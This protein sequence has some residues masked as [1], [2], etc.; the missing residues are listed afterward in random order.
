[1]S[2]ES[3][4]NPILWE[5]SPTLQST[6]EITRFMRWLDGR[7][8]SFSRYGDLWQWSV[9]DV[10]RFWAAVYEYFLQIKPQTVLPERI[11]PG[12]QWFGDSQVNFAE[13]VF[14]RARR[15]GVLIT[16]ENES[17]ETRGLTYQQLQSQVKGLAFTFREWGI[18]PGDRIAAYLPNIPETVVAFLAAASIGAIWS[19]ASPDF[20]P[21]SVLDRFR[22]IDPTVLL[23]VDGYRYNGRDFDR[24][25]VVHRLVEGLPSLRHVVT[26]PYLFPNADWT[27]GHAHAV[28]W[29]DVVQDRSSLRFEPVSFNHPLWVLYSSG[30]TGLPK[31]IVHGHG[32]ML[33]T[34]LVNTVLHLNLSQSDQFFWF[35]TTGWMM[36]NVVISGLLA[37]SGIVLYDG[38]PTHPSP[39]HLW[40]LAERVGVTVF[41]ASAAYLHG[42]MKAGVSPGRSH[43]LS[44]LKTLATTGSPL[45]PE[46]YDWVYEM[47]KP[48]I[49]L[50]PA[51]GGTDICSPFVGGCPLLPVRRGEM[52]CRILGA[53]VEAF[54]E[55]GQALI[56]AVGELVVT[57]PMPAMPLFLW[58]DDSQYTRYKQ[59][60]FEKFP[61]VWTHGDWIR[62]TPEGG[63]VI[64]G[65]SD[66][67]LNRYGVRM[68]TSE[69][70][71]A[72]ARVPEVDDALVV[73]YSP[74]PGQSFMPLFV[75]LM[76]GEHWS[77]SVSEHIR[78]A[79]TTA[80]SPRHLPDA[81]IPVEDIPRTLS[82]KKLEV[83]IKRILQGEPA[84]AVLSV[85]AMANPECLG[86][87]LRYAE[88]MRPSTPP[89]S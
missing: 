59:S 68:G 60:Y 47:V 78:A 85:D 36:W 16:F 10:E 3:H 38:S 70:Y 69:I 27:I 48:D 53:K 71:R 7:Y 11:M 46:A 18:K 2:G 24:R 37:Q 77:Q 55:Q 26:V 44:A 49:Q 4:S 82:G 20:G 34:Q 40:S 86:E 12:A 25:T 84:E 66:S 39:E 83:P 65:R 23:A 74:A 88:Q 73:E 30:T 5:P 32:G 15:G 14:R 58:G 61:G 17:G 45:N 33:L 64:L 22:Q 62:I 35:S 19:V 21:P 29:A 79:I 72:V 75:S 87:Y 57:E 80:L 76:P 41:G 43:D 9:H 50:A 42:L 89:G 54:D 6:A 8:G 52:Q 67:T 56:D 28:P 31:P 81:I 13:E 63:A 51:S 1:M